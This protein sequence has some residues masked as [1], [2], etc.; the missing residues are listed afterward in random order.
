M[1]GQEMIKTN[2]HTHTTWCDGKDSPETVILAAIGKGFSA[3]GF[4]SHAMLP[5]NE[6]DWV[7]VPGKARSYA[8]EIR[9]LAEKYGDRIRVYCGVEA[10]Y[11]P[12]GACPDRAFY[13]EIKPDYII[14]SVHYVKAPDG[15]LVAVDI[16]PEN[17]ADGIRAH[18]E[19]SVEA[20]IR[21]YFAQER[22]MIEKFDF[23]I[24]GHPDLVR[25]F[26]VKSPYF[27]ENDVWYIEELVKT[28][29]VI[30]A[31]GKI[32][33]VNTGAISRGW[34]DDAYPSRPFRDLLR[35]RGVKFVL[36]SDSHS[37]EAVDCA[38]ERFEKCENFV[39]LFD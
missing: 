1:H 34:L 5:E 11:I 33:E 29:D 31:S 23:D 37:A 4:S 18:F 8:E 35:E 27:S 12:G 3:I 20:Y 10:D 9:A 32:V 26:N 21:A 13:E 28:A 17:L 14:G 25:K 6:L 30:A 2:F 16:S 19:G 39:T 22:E 7:L 38:F 15:N 36:N 24:I